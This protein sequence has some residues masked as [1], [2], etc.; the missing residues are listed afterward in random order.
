M[1]RSKPVD[2]G[3]SSFTRTALAVGVPLMF[4]QLI[5]SSVNPGG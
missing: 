3:S 2:R 5:T 1:Q 4:Q